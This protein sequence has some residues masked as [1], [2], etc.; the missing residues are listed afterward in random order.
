MINIRWQKKKTHRDLR[1]HNFETT[2]SNFINL[3]TIHLWN[4]LSKELKFHYSHSSSLSD[5]LQDVL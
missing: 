4:V 1:P 2:G 3:S 5:N